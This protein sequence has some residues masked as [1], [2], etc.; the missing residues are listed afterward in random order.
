MP[1]QPGHLG[2]LLGGFRMDH[3][4]DHETSAKAGDDR[5]HNGSRARKISRQS[6]HVALPSGGQRTNYSDVPPPKRDESTCGKGTKR[7]VRGRD[8]SREWLHA[9]WRCGDN[10]VFGEAEISGIKADKEPCGDLFQLKSS[11]RL[12]PAR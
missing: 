4:R 6:T 2:P 3:V 12:S 9:C 8:I 7:M 5:N 1:L 11:T 10:R